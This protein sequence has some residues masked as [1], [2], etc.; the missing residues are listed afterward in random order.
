[1]RT[2][3][4]IL[5]DVES[6]VVLPARGAALKF[7]AGG[8]SDAGEEAAGVEG[9]GGIELTLDGAHEGKG[10]AGSAP[11][12]ERGK[13]GGA[14]DEDEGAATFFDF[15]A[16]ADESAVQIIGGAIEAEPAEAGG[17]DERFPL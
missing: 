10:I 14:M 12:V 4:G 17:I 2:R 1:M 7:Q 8:G 16:Q 11:G 9:V 13:R 15:G 6:I 5:A 3:G